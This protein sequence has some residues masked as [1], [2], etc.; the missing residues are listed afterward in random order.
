MP[1]GGVAELRPPQGVEGLLRAHGVLPV[2][3]IDDAGRAAELGAALLDGGL[4]CVEVTLRTPAALDALRR[5]SD[6]L[7]ELLVGAGT[8][9]TPRQVDA[10]REAGA[11][12]VLGP[13]FNPA[14]VERCLAHGLPVFPGVC[15]PTE[16]ERAL[17]YGLST[18]K[19]F[20]A[21]SA[22]GADFL[23]ALGAPYPMVEFI[24]TGGINVRNLGFYLELA[25][26]LA[27]GGSW[28]VAPEWIREGRFD[29]VRDEV[30]NAV[31]VV[32]FH[33]RAAA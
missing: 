12:F 4:Y 32:G 33:R 17:G 2:V 16:I 8:V 6:E 7:P 28:M 30:R 5:L 19:F 29:L 23:R 31:V 14:V 20:P 18:V 26:V 13:G 25:N 10:A 1:E 24:P 9:L 3:V 21:E 22:G 15:T 27:C 11:R